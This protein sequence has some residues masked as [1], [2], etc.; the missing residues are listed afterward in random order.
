VIDDKTGIGGD[1][2]EPGPEKP[3]TPGAARPEP[4]PGTDTADG[5]RSDAG[6]GT[7]A[8]RTRAERLADEAIAAGAPITG[9]EA[10]RQVVEA[11]DSLFETAEDLAEKALG[12]ETGRK[13][14]AAAEE[15]K[16]KALDTEAGRKLADAADDLGR[17]ATATEAGSTA[18]QLWNTPLG[19]N[20]GT[21]A[22]AGAA[23]G[24]VV[25]FFG[26]L[27]GAAIGGGLGYLRTLA[28]KR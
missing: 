8:A 15:L 10:G 24:L 9:S 6:D 21:G 28:K 11:A 20:V 3:A 7:G 2:P 1:T 19:R 17:Q 5:T 14:V 12:S 4:E 25:P 27:V 23:I 16:A 22:A 26:P 13:L 18:R